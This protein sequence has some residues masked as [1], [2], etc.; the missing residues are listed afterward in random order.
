MPTKYF[1]V[2]NPLDDRLLGAAQLW[3]GFSLST[4]LTHVVP[5]GA[6]AVDSGM[7]LSTVK[8]AIYATLAW[9]LAYYNGLGVQVWTRLLCKN[10]SEQASAATG[11]IM[12]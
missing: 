10:T 11:R 7:S 6:P 3:V 2:D 8:P 4:Y 9:I 1:W 12:G 5:S